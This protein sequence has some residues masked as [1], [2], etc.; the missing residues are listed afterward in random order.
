MINKNNIVII[1]QFNLKIILV[2]NY[3]KQLDTN[4]LS[5]EL[6]FND[7]IGYIDDNLSQSSSGSVI[8]KPA[9]HKNIGLEDTNQ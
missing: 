3:K 4:Y 6:R 1:K 2:L 8:I 7:K 5:K 9:K